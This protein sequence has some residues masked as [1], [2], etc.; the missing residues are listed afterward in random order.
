MYMHVDRNMQM[1]K[2]LSYKDCLQLHLCSFFLSTA[3]VFLVPS[4]I[5]ISPSFFL[6]ILLLQTQ[7]AL[8]LLRRGADKTKL[9]FSRHRPAQVCTY[10]CA[11]QFV[12]MLANY[13]CVGVWI[14]ESAIVIEHV[15][16]KCSNI[17]WITGFCVYIYIYR[18]G[19]DNSDTESIIA[20]IG[21]HVEDIFVVHTE[22][23]HIV[24]I[25]QYSFSGFN[26]YITITPNGHI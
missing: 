17:P 22:F 23:V 2:S 18:S 1:K 10:A 11:Y 13:A 21:D 19:T 7:C 8:L 24:Y 5:F 20:R 15:Q 14:M 4:S 9:N 25:Y 3:L 26:M 12:W 6:L 16:M